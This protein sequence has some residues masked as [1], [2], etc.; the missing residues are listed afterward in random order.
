MNKARALMIQG[1][2]S[3]VGKSL[4][5]AAF[6]RIFSDEGISVAP[7]KAQNMA[8]NSAITAEGAEIGRAQALQAEAARIE[9]TADMNPIL[10]KTA[11]ESGSQVILHG[12]VHATMQ[13]REYYSHKKMMWA[14]VADSYD[15][16]AEKHGMI[17]IEGAGSPAEINLMDVDIVNMAMARHANAPVI[18]V[19]DVDKGGV[20]AALYGTLGLLA[21]ASAPIKGFLINKFR[22]DRTILEPGLRMI[23]AKTGRPVIGVLPYL[24][25]IGLPEEDGL[26]LS[27]HSACH[28]EH[29]SIRI[30]VIRHRSIANFTDFD[31]LRLEPDVSLIFSHSP[32]DLE[33][34][35][36][37]IIPGSKNTVADLKILRTRGFEPALHAVHERGV[38][39]I[40]ICGGYQML[41]MRIFDEQ[42]IESSEREACGLGLLN[43]TTRFH[44]AKTTCLSGAEL[45]D[46]RLAAGHA[47]STFACHSIRGYEIHMGDS[48]GDIN[49]LRIRRAGRDEWIQEGSQNGSCWGT[50][51]HG[52]FDNDAFRRAVLNQVRLRK[53]LP[54]LETGVSY[55]AARE[56]A[57]DRLADVVREHCDLDAVR[58]M[59]AV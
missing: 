44:A 32:S 16:L 58:R 35:D 18:L 24:Q 45:L 48:S 9:P 42:G 25:S 23:E 8:L 27:D 26:S 11:G 55:R 51:L 46:F 7:F 50:Y 10:L 3:G 19:G 30:V 34:A 28:H 22:G 38:P 56:A 54:S 4:I 13:A 5:A 36:L 37:V 57:L 14:A 53:G 31:A 21:E 41:G 52:L 43:I 39:V 29:G 1:T 20:F 15:R 49:L 33:T 12:K 59:I 6:C 2:G 40:G 47:A 17:V